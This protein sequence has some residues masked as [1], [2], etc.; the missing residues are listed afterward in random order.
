MLEKKVFT[1]LLSLCCLIFQFSAWSVAPQLPRF[2]SKSQP[3]HLA[4]RLQDVNSVVFTSKWSLKIQRGNVYIMIFKWDRCHLLL[5]GTKKNINL[6]RVDV[7]FSTLI[8]Y[9]RKLFEF[10]RCYFQT[11]IS[12]NNHR[13]VFL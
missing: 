12:W 7:A 4:T 6:L 13:K 5:L 11:C 8:K 10:C 2:W 9:F 3:Q 1:S